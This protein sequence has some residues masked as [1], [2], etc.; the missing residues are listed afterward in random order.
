MLGNYDHGIVAV[1]LFFFNIP[2]LLETCPKISVDE[3]I[4]YLVFTL[5]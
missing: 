5:R 4:G 3:M 1:F 2:H